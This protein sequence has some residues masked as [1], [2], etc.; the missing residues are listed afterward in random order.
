MRGKAQR[1]ARSAPQCRPLASSST[2][3]SC[4]HL[5]NVQRLY[6]VLVCLHYGNII[7]LPWQRPLTNWKIRYIS[8][9]VKRIHMV[10]ILR[11]S[12]QYVLRYLTKYDCFLAVSYLT[13]LNELRYLWSYQ[14]EVHLIFTRCSH[15][16]FAV[17]AHI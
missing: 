10:K 15:I 3:K 6:V 4:Y 9:H 1:I 14:A 16:I 2:T 12:F 13:F 8:I 7:W 11:K 5:A 17:N